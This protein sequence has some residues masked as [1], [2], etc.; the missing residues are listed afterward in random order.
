MQGKNSSVMVRIAKESDYDRIIGVVDDWW[1]GRH[2]AAMLPRLFLQH[3]QDTCLVAEDGSK[4]AGFLIGFISQSK[5]TE[6]Y[7]HFA[8]VHPDYRRRGTAQAMYKKFYEIASR[9]GCSTVKLV[10]SPVNKT[11][12]AFHTSIGYEME[13]GNITVDGIPVFLDYDG[14]GE[15]RVRFVL[16]I[17]IE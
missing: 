7:I 14:K 4:L 13:S 17:S 2:M 12:I 10:T 8:G 3:F 1:G 11:S 15:D 5:P 16:H 9:R 6:A